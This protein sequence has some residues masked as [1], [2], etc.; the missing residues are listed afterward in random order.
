M[1]FRIILIFSAFIILAS[2]LGC[3]SGNNIK[4]EIPYEDFFEDQ[5]FTWEANADIG[6]TIV[7]TL[8]SNPTTGFTWPDIA[9]IGNKEILKQVDHTFIPPENTGIVGSSGKDVWIFKAQKKGM[10]TI[11]MDYSRPWEGGEKGE[12]TFKATINVE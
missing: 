9:Q 8:G 1:K 2:F 7:V 10:T 6:D 3:S 4:F 12:W 5:H 11:S